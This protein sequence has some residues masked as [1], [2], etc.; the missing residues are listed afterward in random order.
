M[1]AQQ[2][3]PQSVLKKGMVDSGL[4]SPDGADMLIEINQSISKGILKPEPRSKKNTT[5]TTL[6]E[7]AKTKF[8]PAYYA[9]K[10]ASFSEKI[11]GF[12]LKSFLSVA[13]KRLL[14]KEKLYYN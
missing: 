3:F 11:T 14:K 10:E 4:L 7:F 6:E 13:G 8:A 1:G 5:P 2:E 9:T 12:F